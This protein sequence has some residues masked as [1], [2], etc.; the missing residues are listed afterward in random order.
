MATVLFQICSSLNFQRFGKTTAAIWTYC[1]HNF[2]T[3]EVCWACANRA[4]WLFCPAWFQISPS[5]YFTFNKVTS[6]RSYVFLGCFQGKRNLW[7]SAELSDS[8]YISLSKSSW[9]FLWAIL[10]TTIPVSTYTLQGTVS[11]DPIPLAPTVTGCTA[12][13]DLCAELPVIAAVLSA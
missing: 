13:V 5:C 2:K 3:H 7:G 1:L 12:H 11:Q 10:V 8:I 6:T 4:L 9:V